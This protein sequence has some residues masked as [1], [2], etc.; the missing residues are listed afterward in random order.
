MKKV[1]ILF[2]KNFYIDT[3]DEEITKMVIK[4][5]ECLEMRERRIENKEIELNLLYLKKDK[6]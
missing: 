4:W 6:K 1:G 5:F 2:G 3:D